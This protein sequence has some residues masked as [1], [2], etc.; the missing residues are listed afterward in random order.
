MPTTNQYDS[1]DG[2]KK[3]EVV[4]DTDTVINNLGEVQLSK[5]LVERRFRVFSSEQP[6]GL[7]VRQL[8]YT[9]WPDHDVPRDEAMQSFRDMIDLFVHWCAVSHPL[10]KAIVHCS[11]GIGRTGTTICLASTILQLWH[12]KNNNQKPTLCSVFSTVRRMRERK[13]LMV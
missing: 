12:Q 7:V 2:K 8:H 13:P 3:P 9:G 10:E 4:L 1:P 6:D 5:F 11:A